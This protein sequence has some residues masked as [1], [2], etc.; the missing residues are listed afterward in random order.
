MNL[1]QLQATW[2]QGAEWHRIEDWPK[3]TRVIALV[4]G[5]TLILGACIALFVRPA[6]QQ[7][8]VARGVT[9][10][11]TDLLQ[12]ERAQLRELPTLQQ[13]LTTRSGGQANPLRPE[14]MVMAVRRP[15]VSALESGGN[16]Q[17]SGRASFG[18][19]MHWI[20]SFGSG[21]PVLAQWN[22]MSITRTDQGALEWDVTLVPLKANQTVAAN[23]TTRGSHAWRLGADPFRTRTLNTNGVAIETQVVTPVDPIEA[24]WPR[25]GVRQWPLSSLRFIGTIRTGDQTQALLMAGKQT[26]YRVVAGDRIGTEG[27]RV[28]HIHSRR[29]ETTSG[30]LA[31]GPQRIGSAP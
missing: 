2:L 18:E 12:G 19:L 15:Y 25:P 13:E 9:Q 23:D 20:G 10:E 22:G 30:P 27:A 24:Q 26:V 4:L 7:L 1:A 5:S 28:Q 29:I 6:Y 21:A 17:V 31:L 3:R 16:V 14:T 11:S 8:V